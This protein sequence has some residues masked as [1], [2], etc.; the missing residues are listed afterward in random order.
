MVE[1]VFLPLPYRSR[2]AQRINIPQRRV[3]RQILDPDF[4]R[5]LGSGLAAPHNTKLSFRA[6]IKNVDHFA[7]LQL[8]VHALQRSAASADTAQ[9]GRLSEGAGMSVH[10]PNLNRKVDEDTWL[11]A[12][13]HAMLL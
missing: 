3:S 5:Y 10:A 7:R 1:K 2:A 6:L 9:A 4:A 11:V 13:I 8:S 12:P